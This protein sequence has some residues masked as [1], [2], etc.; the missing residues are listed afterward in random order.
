MQRRRAAQRGVSQMMPCK[1][2]AVPSKRDIFE[3]ATFLY[4]SLKEVRSG[5]PALDAYREFWE[6]N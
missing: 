5:H 3:V 6:E 2:I 1:T 4:A